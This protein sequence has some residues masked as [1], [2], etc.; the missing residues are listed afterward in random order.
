MDKDGIPVY[1]FW[2]KKTFKKNRDFKP[3]LMKEMRFT[4]QA[5]LHLRSI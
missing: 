5:A 4:P 1:R 2:V 3:F